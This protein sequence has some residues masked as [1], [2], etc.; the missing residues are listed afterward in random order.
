MAPRS[1]IETDLE[2][3]KEVLVRKQAECVAH[4]A[5]TEALEDAVLD[6]RCGVVV[7]MAVLETRLGAMTSTLTEIKDTLTWQTRGLIAGLL[8]IVGVGLLYIWDNRESMDSHARDLAN[9]MEQ[10]VPTP[11]PRAYSSQD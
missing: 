10:F 11:A 1:E 4:G 8:M 5:K 2:H 6:P 9:R 7:Q 3:L